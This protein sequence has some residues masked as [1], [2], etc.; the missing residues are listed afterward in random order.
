M[1]ATNTN[2]AKGLL[3]TGIGGLALTIDIP[4]LKLSGGEAWSVLLMRTGTTFLS[5]LVIWAIWRL[6]TPSAPKLVPGRKGLIVAGLY[7][8]G[9]IFFITAVYNTTTANLVFI[10]AFNTMFAA[11]LSWI[12]LGERPRGG[13]LL[14]MAAMILGILIIVWDSVGT[15]NLFGDLMAACAALSLAAAITISRASNDDMGFTALVGVIFPFAVAAFMVGGTGFRVD[16]PWWLLFNG[17]VIM[18]LSFFC[19]A[20]GPRYISGPEVAM[21]YLLETV[22]APVWMW[23]IFHE[24]PSRASLTGGI[25]LIT[26]LVAHSIWQLAEGRKRRAALAVRYP[27]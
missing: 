14:A 3:I 15:G 10:L 6:I 2:H 20:Q 27:A 24:T 23:L 21:F 19:L 26:A 18:P 13:T 1:P 17:A 5:A 12:F 16:E 9:S 8:L 22:L 11:L 4:L 25:I 7:G